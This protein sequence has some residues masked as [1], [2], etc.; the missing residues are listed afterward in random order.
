MLKT[1]LATSRDFI[2]EQNE[3]SV[4]LRFSN[5]IGEREIL[6]KQ[7]LFLHWSI[8]T[9]F[10]SCPQQSSSVFLHPETRKMFSFSDKKPSF[11]KTTYPG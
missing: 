1:L 9:T 5:A 7:E 11:N 8:T 6:C 3:R 2:N 10:P 4:F